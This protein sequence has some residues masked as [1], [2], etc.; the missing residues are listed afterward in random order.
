MADDD[1]GKSRKQLIFEREIAH[2][3]VGVCNEQIAALK[4]EIA[5]LRKDNAGLAE[6]IHQSDAELK[7][8][9][10]TAKEYAEAYFIECA[11]LKAELDN[12]NAAIT[13]IVSERDRLRADLMVGNSPVPP[14]GY[15]I[16]RI[17]VVVRLR[18]KQA[19]GEDG[20]G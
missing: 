19:G 3:V 20:G 9:L 4:A 12:I 6:L 13:E 8:E 10:K 1:N 11:E 14:E 16:A 7:A 15:Q 2:D 18:R 17:D 5:K